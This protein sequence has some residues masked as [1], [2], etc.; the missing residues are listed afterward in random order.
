MSWNG[1]KCIT[2]EGGLNWFNLFTTLALGS[3][4]VHKPTSYS[5]RVKDF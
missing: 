1:Q 4:V 5:V 3:A 2:G